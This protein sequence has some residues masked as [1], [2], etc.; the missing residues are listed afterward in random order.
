MPY[1][2]PKQYLDKVFITMN[3]LDLDNSICLYSQVNGALI[4]NET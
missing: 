2:N 1:M 4:K 3:F